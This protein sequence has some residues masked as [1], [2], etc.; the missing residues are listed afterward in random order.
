MVLIELGLGWMS[1][2]LADVESMARLIGVV[3]L[4]SCGGSY[5]AG[6]CSLNQFWDVGVGFGWSCLVAWLVGICSCDLLGILQLVRWE[7]VIV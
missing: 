7:C 6:Y 3:L 4:P 1:L 5:Q 2:V